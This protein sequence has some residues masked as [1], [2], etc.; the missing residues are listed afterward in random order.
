ML[1]PKFWSGSLDELVNHAV[2][3]RASPGEISPQR[4]KRRLNI[5]PHCPQL[6]LRRKSLRTNI[7][8]LFRMSCVKSLRFPAPQHT[9][10]V[11]IDRASLSAFT[12]LLTMPL[13]RPTQSPLS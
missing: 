7:N 11:Q 10:S 9:L 8:D 3:L 6:S 12:A 5:L 1:V 2:P 4:T 13:F